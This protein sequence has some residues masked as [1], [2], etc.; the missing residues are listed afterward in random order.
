MKSSQG[1][2][3]LSEANAYSESAREQGCLTQGKGCFLSIIQGPG[4]MTSDFWKWTSTSTECSH[5]KE[6]DNVS[7]VP[8]AWMSLKTSYETLSAKL[9]RRNFILVLILRRDIHLWNNYATFWDFVHSC[10]RSSELAIYSGWILNPWFSQS[11]P[12]GT[13]CPD[14]PM[15]SQPRPRASSLTSAPKQIPGLEFLWTYHLFS[16]NYFLWWICIEYLRCVRGYGHQ[17]DRQNFYFQSLQS[18]KFVLDPLEFAD[19]IDRQLRW[20]PRKKTRAP[21]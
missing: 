17:H 20:K 14:L 19:E 8:S 7:L 18:S 4:L 6:L 15:D 11:C 5:R 21:K 13:A 3:L 2:L 10:K 9:L 12:R 16:N 1:G